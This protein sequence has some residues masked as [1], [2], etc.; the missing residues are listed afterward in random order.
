MSNHYLLPCSCGQKLRVTAAQAGGEVTCGCGRKLTVPTLRGLRELEPAPAVATAKQA[1][2]WSLLH[3]LSFSGG[4]LLILIGIALLGYHLYRYSQVAGYTTDQT[5]AFV[6]AH[7]A[8]V[9]RLTPT[10]ML[11]EWSKMVS[12]GLGEK[13]MTPWEMARRMVAANQFWMGTGG[14]AILVGLLMSVLSLFVGR[15]STP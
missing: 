2:G 13:S 1:P 12:E 11:D 9:D 5:D 10:E 14:L 4:I 15:P 3:G 6:A 7:A 8:D